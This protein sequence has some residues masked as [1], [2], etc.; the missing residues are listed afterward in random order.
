MRARCSSDW[1][2]S[3]GSGIEGGGPFYLGG[4][5]TLAAQRSLGGVEFHPQPAYVDHPLEA[6]SWLK[7][8]CPPGRA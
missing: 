5:D 7:D 3:G 4:R 6:N 1:V 8:G 2:A